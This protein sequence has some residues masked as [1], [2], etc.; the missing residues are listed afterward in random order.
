M[1]FPHRKILVVGATSGIGAALAARFVRGGA[2]VLVVGRRRERL[3]AFVAAHGEDK[4]TALQLDVTRLE[5]IPGFSQRVTREHPDL[6]CVVLNSGIQRGFDFSS[7]Q[8]VDLDELEREFRTNYLSY[9]HLTTAFLP[10]LQERKEGGTLIYM[11]SGLAL[12]PLPRCPNYSATKAAL[13]Q[14]LLALRVQLRESRVKIV[15]ILPPA[16]QTELHDEKHQPDIKNGGAMGMP[17]DEFT[18]E[19]YDGLVRGNDEIP[20]GQAK[21]WYASFEPKRQEAYQDFLKAMGS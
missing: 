13:H 18:D 19:A 10:F 4:A 2:H 3:D 15:E 21:E 16:V 17:L 7:P 20:V 9:V 5:E 1:S 12:L 11:S 8:S 14:F 6:S